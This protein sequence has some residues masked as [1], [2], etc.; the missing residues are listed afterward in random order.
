MHCFAGEHRTGVFTAVYRMEFDGWSNAD[1]I[2]EME[3]CGFT[4]D[5][6]GRDIVTYLQYYIPR[7][8]GG[9]AE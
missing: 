1:A 3:D 2:A 5:E 4:V 7:R 9:S 6:G 8:R